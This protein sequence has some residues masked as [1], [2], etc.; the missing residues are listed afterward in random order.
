MTRIVE[1]NRGDELKLLSKGIPLEQFILLLQDNCVLRVVQCAL[2]LP[3]ENEEENVPSF[4][5]KILFSLKVS[6][7]SNSKLVHQLGQLSGDQILVVRRALR[8]EV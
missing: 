1:M 5:R 4:K 8:L 6:I 3:G 2:F 7:E